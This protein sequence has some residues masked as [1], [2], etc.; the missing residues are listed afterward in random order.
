SC[1]HLLGFWDNI[2]LFAFLSLGGRCRYCRTPISWRYFGVELLT[3]C[4]W[5]AL[6]NHVADRNP[7]TWI[8]F[9]AQALFVSILVAV[10]F[11]DLDHF[12]IPDELNWF[13][14]GLGIVR[15]VACLAVAWKMGGYIFAQAADRYSYFHWLPRSIPGALLYGG[16]LYLVSFAAFVVYARGE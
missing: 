10:I 9:L 14:T 1:N 5:T 4:L 15:D 16:V 12:I 6:F 11:I 13:G 2:P 7:I 8:D 3:A